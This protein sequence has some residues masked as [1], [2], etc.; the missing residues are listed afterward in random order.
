MLLLVM[1][2]AAAILVTIQVRRPKPTGPYAGRPLPPMQVAGWINV[3]KPLT[4][5][6]LQGKIVLVDFWATWCRPC[7]RGIPELIKF[8]NQYRDQGVAVVGLTA[9]D[10]DAAEQVK[11]FVQSREGMNWPVGYGARLPFEMMGIEGIPTYMLFDRTGTSVW[12][13]HSLY[14]IEDALLPLLA[15]K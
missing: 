9:E 4:N 8:N 2:L 13:G 5:E 11:S 6:D 15:E 10:G 7:V 1:G 3:D 14:G 12:G